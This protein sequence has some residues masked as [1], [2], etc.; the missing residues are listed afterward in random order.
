MRIFK[1]E[2]GNKL[3]ESEQERKASTYYRHD[4]DVSSLQSELEEKLRKLSEL[5]CKV[6]FVIDELDKMDYEDVVDV[7][8]S[9]KTLFNQASALFI[10]I[11]GQEFFTK[12]ISSTARPTEYTLFPQKIFLQRP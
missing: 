10:V 4:Y 7:I 2:Y 9:L 1:I 3:S 5:N 6:I 11:S 8:K 12:L